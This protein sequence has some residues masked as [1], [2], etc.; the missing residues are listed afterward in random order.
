M[1][2]G[3][4]QLLDPDPL[5]RREAILGRLLQ[6]VEGVLTTLFDEE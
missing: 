3:S 1:V 2:L 6:V 4:F 5:C